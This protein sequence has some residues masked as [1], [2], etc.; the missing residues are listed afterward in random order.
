MTLP[1]ET[2]TVTNQHY[3]A[4][5]LMVLKAALVERVQAIDASLDLEG[6]TD[7]SLDTAQQ[8]LQAAE[9]ALPAPAA[10]QR[11]CDVCR[12]TSFERDTLLLCAGMELDATFAPLF[13]AMQGDPQRHYPTFGLALGNLA[14]PNWAALSP[15]GPLRF[16]QLL[17]VGP[18]RALTLSPLRID[19]RVLNFLTGIH[20]LDAQ[21]FGLV[22]PLT[23]S[24]SALATLVPS[25]QALAEQLAQTWTQAKH[26]SG[27]IPTLQLSGGDSRDR[28][29][30][31]QAAAAQLGLNTHAMATT[32]LPT[33][34]IDL[35]ALARRWR[36]EA[37]FSQSALLLEWEMGSAGDGAIP[38][39]LSQF[40][41]DVDSP[42]ILSTAAR[43]HLP[44][45]TL[46]SFDVAYPTPPEQQQLWQSILGEDAT[47]IN[48]EVSQLVSQFNLNRTLIH[49]AYLSA[50]ANAS[51][52]PHLRSAELTSKPIP[53]A[54]WHACRT[55][56]RPHMDAHAQRLVAKATWD[57]LILPDA[58]KGV[59]H[60]MAAHLRQRTRVYQDW[61][62]ADQGSRGLGITALFSGASGT[63]KTLAAEV[64]AAELQLDLYKIDLSA[65]VSKYIGETEK[66]LSQVFDAAETGGAILL[67][68]EADALFG[69]RNDVKD[70]HDRYAN[71]E[72]SYLLQRMEAYRGLAILTTNLPDAI[73]RAFLRRIRF[74]VQFPFP[75]V[76]Q[77]TQI[78]QRMFPPQTPTDG[79]DFRKL[80]RL[81]VA[82]G[83]IRNITL[84][85]AFLAADANEPVQMKHLLRAT[86]SEYSKL[87]RP[88]TD[89]EIRGWVTTPSLASPM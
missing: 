48:G 36:R 86:Q 2:W 60:E 58:E 11:L 47:T 51:S 84:N 20:H 85:A 12:L 45:H 1:S 8:Q 31:A 57:D 67:F 40:L 46:V 61:G 22:K 79:L 66:N 50:L 77:R 5:T 21:L 62:F 69:K 54:L 13:A 10:L 6:I 28:R 89:A 4:A 33:A 68:D 72:V 39:A 53:Q 30:I 29:T 32:A 64:L 43:Q 9:S 55:Q 7:L 15:S 83:N 16:W 49:S 70:S 52:S 34:P 27:T 26:L 56:A 23:G 59:L 37:I 63:G 74:I 35:N 3:L 17:E 76:A 24:E 73:D 38:T 82:G 14:E 81:N 78:W 42:V 25:H 71:I 44:K 87:D 80:A 19:E 65:I 88:I 75:D 18:G 41:E